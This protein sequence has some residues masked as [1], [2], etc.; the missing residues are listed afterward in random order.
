MLGGGCFSRLGSAVVQPLLPGVVAVALFLALLLALAF[1]VAPL[2]QLLHLRHAQLGGQQV[3][4]QGLGLQLHMVELPLLQVHRLLQALHEA[5]V[6]QQ[7]VDAG[8]AAFACGVAR[9]GV[10]LVALQLLQLPLQPLQPSLRLLA[11]GLRLVA[12]LFGVLQ[13]DGEGACHGQ[14]WASSSNCVRESARLAASCMS[15]CSSAISCGCS[16]TAASRSTSLPGW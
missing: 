1:D 16:C 9:F 12:R 6:H 11:L 8:G 14:G 13:Q 2:L 5:A 7:R 10:A 4:L 3:G 15:C